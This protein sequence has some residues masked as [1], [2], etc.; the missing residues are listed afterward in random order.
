MPA[1]TVL[2]ILDGFGANPI[3]LGNAVLSA[4]TP[5]L[6]ALWSHYPHTLLKAAEEE[7]GLSF[8]E[9]GNSEVGHL[10]I[11]TGRVLLQSLPRISQSITDKSFF[12]NPAL[13]AAI[14]HAKKNNS[15]LHIMG[16]VSVAGVHAHLD[17]MLAL[18]EL[19]SKHHLSRL[20]I[21]PI[22]DGR[23][24][25]PHDAPI[26]L[27][28]L[29]EAI[30]YYHLG[31]IATLSGRAYAMDR[32]RNWERT[33]LFYQAL[34]GQGP[35]SSSHHDVIAQNYAAGSDD[36]NLLPTVLIDNQGAPLGALQ[37]ND[38]LIFTNFREDRARQITQMLTSSPPASPPTPPPANLFITTMTRYDNLLPTSVAFEPVIPANT[39]SDLLYQNQL[40]QIHISETEKYAHLTYFFNG[41]RETPHPTER[42]I[43]LPSPKPETFATQPQMAAPQ[44]AQTALNALA[45]GWPFIII[46]FA[47][48]DMIAHTGSLPATVSAINLIDTLVGQ[49]F[50]AVKAQGGNLFLTADHGNAES[51]ID[52]ASKQIT[53]DHTS[54]PV[55]FV[56]ALP[57][58]ENPTAPV[59]RI[60]TG[61]SI[62]GLLADVAP[63]ILHFLSL[64]IPPE[65]TGT[66]IFQ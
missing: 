61:A 27:K 41:G 31:T 10:A 59:S 20:Y 3:A 17:H 15:R 30:N 23:D 63:T 38:A 62:T 65:M 47:N 11:G 56:A 2:I 43:Q 51:M 44:I 55:P 39:L 29:Q 60:T 9:M 26:F 21:H 50:A 33:V 64:P 49:I 34:L 52:P 25:G 1:P 4:T 16:M 8:G 14:N 12:T 24:S 7:V 36:E 54:N 58:L 13:L 19:A 66:P 48:P 5:N 46:N 28:K 53:K 22:L 40:P 42:F 32:N 35:T 18:I 6:D 57:R 37:D 45:K